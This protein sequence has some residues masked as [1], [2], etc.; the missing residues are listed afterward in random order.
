MDNGEVG[1]NMA[2]DGPGPGRG[3]SISQVIAVLLLGPQ[4]V[5]LNDA[6]AAVFFLFSSGKIMTEYSMIA[7][8]IAFDCHVGH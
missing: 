7:M 6:K 5:L 1:S 3:S 4:W 2:W 8:L